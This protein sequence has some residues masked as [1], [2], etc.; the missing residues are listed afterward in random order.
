MA[1]E[2]PREDSK[3]RQLSEA[4]KDDTGA[5]SESSNTKRHRRETSRR[6]SRQG[7][8][9]SG[10]KSSR[11]TSSRHELKSPP[12]AAPEASS[13]DAEQ[14]AGFSWTSPEN[15][16]T[17]SNEESRLKSPSDRR[18]AG[19]SKTTSPEKLATEAAPRKTPSDA[20]DV[21]V[22]EGAASAENA[23]QPVP[24]T[25][26]LSTDIT[27][28]ISDESA[29]KQQTRSAQNW[30]KMSVATGAEPNPKPAEIHDTGSSETS[31]QQLLEKSNVACDG[32]SPTTEARFARS[33]ETSLEKLE[34]KRTAKTSDQSSPTLAEKIS[35]KKSDMASHELT[36]EPAGRE[37]VTS[38]DG[39]SPREPAQKSPI[40]SS[41]E[42]V[43]EIAEERVARSQ[44]LS[45]ASEASTSEPSGKHH[46]SSTAAPPWKSPERSNVPDDVSASKTPEE[47]TAGSTPVT[48]LRSILKSGKASEAGSPKP[49]EKQDTVPTSPR[50]SA[51]TW[52]ISRDHSHFKS[53]KHRSTRSI[54]TS[55][56][57]S[58]E[59]TTKRS[60]ESSE[61]LGEKRNA[62]RLPTS[63]DESADRVVVISEGE[64]VVKSPTDGAFDTCASEAVSAGEHHGHRRK[65]STRS[66]GTS[67][68][69]WPERTPAMSPDGA[70]A[71]DATGVDSDA[72]GNCKKGSSLVREREFQQEAVRQPSVR[73]AC[74]AAPFS[75]LAL[76]GPGARTP[77]QPVAQRQRGRLRGLSQPRHLGSRRDRIDGAKEARRRRAHRQATSNVYGPM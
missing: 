45:K 50:K 63:P 15:D 6:G 21:D 5:S 23:T 76:R 40:Y 19:T 27:G 4:E 74:A 56:T 8:R 72:L 32:S 39:T 44:G 75:R 25:Q 46:R 77:L 70:T 43:S 14:F 69:D 11:R 9:L 26:W 24:T 22:D 20:S 3:R 53:A 65:P 52:R 35:E 41:D 59:R 54:S 13:A 37:Q 28:A 68:I 2:T 49:Y 51:S 60:E 29:G 61:K 62:R 71:D 42:T 58:I 66:V 31:P 33:S 18:H 47:R 55:P 12:D 64:S 30:A 16:W 67:P 1:D 57:T 10:R 48:P 34:G 36:A 7:S 38:G 73:H 17:T